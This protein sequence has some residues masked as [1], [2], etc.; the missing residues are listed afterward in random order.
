[1]ITVKRDKSDPLHPW[2]EVNEQDLNNAFTSRIWIH[3]KYLASRT[4]KTKENKNYTKLY[5]ISDLFYIWLYFFVHRS[6]YNIGVLICWL[7]VEMNDFILL[8]FIL[9]IFIIIIYNRQVKRCTEG[10][11]Y[12][13]TQIFVT[14]VIDAV[15]QS[16]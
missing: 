3:N 16:F 7:T 6:K 2:R 1:M 15:L 14:I 12:L 5:F 13:D 8:K 11:R 10:I 9:L 4:V